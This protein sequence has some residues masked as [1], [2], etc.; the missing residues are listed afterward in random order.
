MPSKAAP[1]AAETN[2]ITSFCNT[3]S[4]SVGAAPARDPRGTGIG[5]GVSFATTAIVV[6]IGNSESGCEIANAEGYFTV[7]LVLACCANASAAVSAKADAMKNLGN[8]RNIASSGGDWNSVG[9]GTPPAIALHCLVLLCV[10]CLAECVG[11]AGEARPRAI[12][13]RSSEKDTPARGDNQN[14]EGEQPRN[15]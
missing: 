14:T 7:A 9:P 4:A 10:S 3:E 5:R 6:S 2:G 13:E 15:P 8:V 12:H 11:W 1:F